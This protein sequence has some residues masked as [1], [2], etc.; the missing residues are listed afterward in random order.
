MKKVDHSNWAT[1]VVLVPKPDKT[2][3]MCGDYKTTIN[4]WVRTEGYPLPTVQDLFSTLAGGTVFTKL[5]LKQAYQQLE[6]DEN[7]QE[8]LTIN[9]HKGLYKY[10][11]LPLGVS[12]APSIFQATMDQ[13]LH[14]VNNTICY[15]DDILVMGK[16]KEEHLITLEEVLKRLQNYGLKV[17]LDKCQF[18]QQSVEYLGHTI[19]ALGLH[20]TM[21]KIKAVV[22]APTPKNLSELKSYLGLLNYY[23]RF[24]PNLSSLIQPLNQLQSKD[25]KWEWSTAC[26]QAFEFS[27]QALV[28]SSALT[29]YDATKPLQLACDASP[30]GVGTVLSQYDA[31]GTERPIAFASRTLS[32]AEKN[33]AQIEREA[34]AIIFGVR[35][36]HQYLYG[37][38]FTLFTDHKPLTSILGPKTG[39]PTLAAARM[40]RWA[41]ILSA[42]QYNIMYHNSKENANA[43]AMLRLPSSSNDSETER[44]DVFQT[45]FLDELPI[46][47]E[48]IN[49]ATKHDTIL[50]QVSQYILQRWPNSLNGLPESIRPYYNRKDEL[51][52]EQGCVLWG[53][54]V[55]IP[56]QFRER[57]L[58]QI[59]EEH[60][61]ICKMKALARCYLW[62]PTLDKDIETKVKSCTICMAVRN[63]PQVASS[64]TLMAMAN[65]NLA[66]ASH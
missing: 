7:S 34:L 8:Y 65:T 52:V 58:N 21:A 5:D 32:T 29:H 11:R 51:T 10:T 9:T 64:L 56:E 18:L 20:P 46:R 60:P 62:W 37:R 13:I 1:P 50:S 30:F 43:D 31:D 61:G 33:Y 38:V 23:G 47:S 17:Y 2:I 19:D 24:L 53:I 40:Q 39:I 54:R 42:Y 44:D 26:Q 59:H 6:V 35:K 14:G 15:L 28:S 12:S 27:K 3:R 4:Q 22:D 57:L 16:S 63:T 36:F 48:D 49:K 45:I 55:V 66:K 25:Q 41:L